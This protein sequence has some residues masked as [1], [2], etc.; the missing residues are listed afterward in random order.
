MDAGID[1]TESG[2]DSIFPELD[3]GYPSP[4]QVMFKSI[5]SSASR[6]PDRPTGQTDIQFLPRSLLSHSNESSTVQFFLTFHK[7]CISEYHY[8][9]YID[10]EELFTKELF[11]MAT[12]SD[13]VRYAMTAFSALVYSIKNNPS[14]TQI[15]FVYYKKAFQKFGSSLSKY[16]KPMETGESDNAIAT[17]LLLSSF[18]VRFL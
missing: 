10:I 7:E 2:P 9:L 17:A 8:F 13:S 11:A 15:A 6:S 3:T 1:S 5:S 14:S 18:S 4:G 12:E 16:S